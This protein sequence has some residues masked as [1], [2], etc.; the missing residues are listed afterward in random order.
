MIDLTQKLTGVVIDIPSSVQVTGFKS[1]E[2]NLK[3]DF[4]NCTLN[5]AIRLAAD[6]RRITWANG[7]RA[8]G[9]DHMKTLSPVQ[10]ILVSPPGTRG[11]IDVEAGFMSKMQSASVSEL[12][13]KIKELEAMKTKTI[14]KKK[15]V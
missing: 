15:E 5:D 6:P 3:M 14:L 10:E 1:R 7:H 4:S 2:F 9:E 8:K 13:A 11:T 12:D